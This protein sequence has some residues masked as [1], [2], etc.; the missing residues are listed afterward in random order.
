MITVR[1]YAHAG[2]GSLHL[3]L[4]G[5]AA[6]APKGEDLICAA[7]TTLACTAARGAEDMYRQGKLRKKPRV[8][9]ES[10]RAEIALTPKAEDYAQAL[11][12]LWTLQCGF[13]WLAREYP[14]YVRLAAAV[15]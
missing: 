11:H 7:V 3:H 9:L 1:I 6:S 13:S 12:L 5:H 14:Q 8:V 2:R 4:R 10:G 15:R